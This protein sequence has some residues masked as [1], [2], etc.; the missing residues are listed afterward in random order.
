MLAVNQYLCT[1]AGIKRRYNPCMTDTNL[2]SACPVAFIWRV[3]TGVCK[4]P[5]LRFISA[6]VHKYW[7][8]AS[9]IPYLCAAPGPVFRANPQP[10]RESDIGAP[11]DQLPAPVQLSGVYP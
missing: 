7:F 8:T 1:S 2:S 10:E 4:T 3:G 6:D 5:Y 9:F 11:V